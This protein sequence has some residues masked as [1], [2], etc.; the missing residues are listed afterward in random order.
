M[1]STLRKPLAYTGAYYA[2]TGSSQSGCE[3]L[4]R[5]RS[6]LGTTARLV[7]R[8]PDLKRPA[9]AGIDLASFP[10]C[11]DLALV[12]QNDGARPV[13]E[14]VLLRRLCGGILHTRCAPSHSV[15]RGSLRAIRD[16]HAHCS[17]RLLKNYS[18]STGDYG[19]RSH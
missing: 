8:P 11:P 17:S 9:V 12:R 2:S 7:Q 13:G 18:Q 5:C 6:L 15:A 4:S 3:R 16:R 14:S 1:Q 10:S 19:T